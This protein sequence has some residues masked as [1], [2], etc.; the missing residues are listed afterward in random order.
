MNKIDC[1]FVQKYVK[2]WES[3]HDNWI[4]DFLGKAIGSTQ[5]TLQGIRLD[6]K[7]RLENDWRISLGFLL[8]RTT[9]QSRKDKMND[10]T[11]NYLFLKTCSLPPIYS[12]ESIK[13]FIRQIWHEK[14]SG[15]VTHIRENIDIRRLESISEFIIFSSEKNITKVVLKEID[16]HSDASKFLIQFHCIG[17]KTASFYLKFIAWLFDLS[18]VPIV[19]DTHVLSM[20][21]RRGVI[22]RKNP[23]DARAAILALAQQ[24]SLSPIKIETALYE[25]SWLDTNRSTGRATTLKSCGSITV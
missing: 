10:K 1:D 9:Y 13:N 4:K 21:H 5:Q 7:G 19:I 22:A 18:I 20:L 2:S 16:H 17:E 8:N 23:Q 25:A 24:L 12:E 3:R 15:Q 11:A 14:R 6:L